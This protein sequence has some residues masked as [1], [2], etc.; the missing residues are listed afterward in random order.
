MYV[1]MY[2]CIRIYSRK[3][4][5]DIHYSYLVAILSCGPSTVPAL[6]TSHAPYIITNK[7]T[8]HGENL[9]N[10]QNKARKNYSYKRFINYVGFTLIFILIPPPFVSSSHHWVLLPSI[11]HDY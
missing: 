9:E 1:C 7:G 6:H 11:G 5:N 3:N 10:A 2:V 8:R 4:H